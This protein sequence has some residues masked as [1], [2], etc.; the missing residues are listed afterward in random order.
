M[1]MAEQLREPWHRMESAQMLAVESG[2]GA[3]T[4]TRPRKEG[5]YSVFP[6]DKRP[7]DA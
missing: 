6:R 3:L 5:V 7:R 4:A 1:A 2:N